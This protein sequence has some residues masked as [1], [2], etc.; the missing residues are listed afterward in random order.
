VV[1]ASDLAHLS[2]RGRYAFALACVEALCSAWEVDDP[3]I[4]GEIDAHWQA[5]QVELV[6]HW[7]DAHPFP[8][9]VANFAA[10][11]RAGG[12]TV[13]RV[14]SLHHALCDTRFVLGGSCYA[15]ADDP[16]SMQAVLDVVG[17]LA[18]WGV[19]L[20]RLE[21][22]AHATWSG[23]FETSGWGERFGRASFLGHARQ[24]EPGAAPDPAGTKR[25]RGL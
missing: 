13:D 17:I 21:W 19:A 16:G 7:F 6:C 14:Q 1:H 23:E 5:A 10:R 9:P 25:Y 24:A 22:F 2:L 8:W 3:Y 15:A 20:P 4:Q 11:L 18:R 12:L